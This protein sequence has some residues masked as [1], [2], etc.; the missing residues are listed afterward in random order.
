MRKNMI[1]NLLF[2]IPRRKDW[3]VF[4]LL[5][6][7]DFFAIFILYRDR[8]HVNDIVVIA[9]PHTIHTYSMATTTIWYFCGCPESWCTCFFAFGFFRFF[10]HNRNRSRGRF[11]RFL[12]CMNAVYNSL[13]FFLSFF[14]LFRTPVHPFGWLVRSSLSFYHLFVFTM[15]MNVFLF[16]IICW[17]ESSIFFH[18]DDHKLSWQYHLLPQTNTY[19]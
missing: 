3:N 9:K 5:A 7:A 13:F 17:P 18:W 11:N 14:I 4:R 15:C 2:F 19:T 16:E 10:C 12:F 1:E 8:T 6:F